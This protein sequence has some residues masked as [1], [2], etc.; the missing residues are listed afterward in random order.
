MELNFLSIQIINNE[1]KKK[2]VYT[3][4]LIHKTYNL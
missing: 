3:I 4:A 1:I 2:K